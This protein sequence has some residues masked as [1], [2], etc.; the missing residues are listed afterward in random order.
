VEAESIPA[1][2]AE[3]VTFVNVD[4]VPMDSERVLEGQT[5]VV[6]DGRIVDLGPSS[7]IE[8][9]AGALVVDGEGKFLMPGLSDMHMHLFGAE[10]DLLLYVANGVTTIRDMGGAPPVQLEWR[11]EINAGT[12]VGPHM[13]QWSPMFETMDTLDSIIKDWETSGGMFNAKAP[14]KIEQQVAE[15]A[16]QGYDGIKSHVVFSTDIF[17]AILNS[18]KKHELPWDGHAPID[19]IYCEDKTPCWDSFRSLGVEA[20]AHIEELTKLVDWS[21]ESIRQAA[22]DVAADGMWVT[23]TIALMRSI[24]DQISDL[25]GELAGLP[26]VKYVNPGPFN[27]RWVPEENEYPILPQRLVDMKRPVFATKLAADEMMLLALNEA[28]ASLLSGSDA[29][30]PLMVPGFSLHDELEV[31]VDIGLSPYN[32]LRTTTYNP[33]LYLNKL[34]E[35]GTVE[36]GKRADLLLLEANPLVDITNTRQIAGVM[37]G[38]RWYTR[39]DL[40]LMLDEVA[41]A[42]E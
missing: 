5:V 3:T 40:D 26:E 10:T 31:M 41:N 30:L 17:E 22:Q 11:D 20:V 18:A 36:V 25:E 7:T 15:Y 9:P 32:T 2:T 39:A 34:D 33:A 21:D 29:P 23:T 14:E 42:Y 28:G 12:R 1:G 24:A 35:F 19:L 38:G 16:A 13:L 6:I 37:V 8:V 27:S 4:V